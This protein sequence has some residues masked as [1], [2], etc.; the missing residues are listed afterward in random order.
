MVCLLLLLWEVEA[1]ALEGGSLRGQAAKVG[2]LE[3]LRFGLARTDTG[4]EPGWR[5]LSDYLL[6]KTPSHLY[7][8]P[9]ARTGVPPKEL[10]GNLKAALLQI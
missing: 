7:V 2:G 9:S 6:H 5:V 4:S 10:G 1:V 3:V 8:L